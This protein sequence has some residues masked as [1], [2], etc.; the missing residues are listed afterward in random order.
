MSMPSRAKALWGEKVKDAAHRIVIAVMG[1]VIGVFGMVV[2]FR[3]NIMADIIIRAWIMVVAHGC[4]EPLARGVK[5]I[6]A[7]IM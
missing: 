2:F 5:I 4:T 6:K 7:Q 3:S 1:L